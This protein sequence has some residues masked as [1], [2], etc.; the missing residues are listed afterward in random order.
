MTVLSCPYADP[1][2]TADLKTGHP[3]RQPKDDSPKTIVHGRLPKAIIQS[4]YIGS[5]D[6]AYGIIASATAFNL[7]SFGFGLRRVFVVLSA[8]AMHCECGLL[9]IESHRDRNELVLV[10]V[11][12]IVARLLS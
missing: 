3:C 2:R 4:V 6:V 8:F 5:R 11:V 10:V 9:V 1:F 7:P 12:T